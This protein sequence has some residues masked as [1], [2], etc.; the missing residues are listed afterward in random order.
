MHTDEWILCNIRWE[1]PWTSF[2]VCC[3]RGCKLAM[4]LLFPQVFPKAQIKVDHLGFEM[5]CLLLTNLGEREG[6]LRSWPIS[7]RLYGKRCSPN[8]IYIRISPTYF[9]LLVNYM[10]SNCCPWNLSKRYWTSVLTFSSLKIDH[11]FLLFVF[12][13]S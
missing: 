13:L 6:K 5:I 2:K 9:S 8:A 7:P 10:F 11:L 12:H 3:S 4:Y 1:S